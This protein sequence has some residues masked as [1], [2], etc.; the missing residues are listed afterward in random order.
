VAE[1]PTSDLIGRL[2]G[3]VDM[4]DIMFELKAKNSS[5]IQTMFLATDN[6]EFWMT[7]VGDY[8]GE[9]IQIDFDEM[10]VT[11]LE[12]MKAAIELIIEAA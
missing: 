3:A 4:K 11:D 7:L 2:G 1:G 5:G 6:G 9:K 10:T 12:D 8:K